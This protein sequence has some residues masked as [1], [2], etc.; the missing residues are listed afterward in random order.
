MPTYAPL[1]SVRSSQTHLLVPADQLG[2]LPNPYRSR[3]PW[4][5]LTR[6]DVADLRPDY[7]AGLEADGAVLI[8]AAVSV[9]RVML[10]RR[11]RR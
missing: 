1:R 4:Q 2:S 7:R 10:R 11:A 5:V 9:V 6:G 3:G 8:E